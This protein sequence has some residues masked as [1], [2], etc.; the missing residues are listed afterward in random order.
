MGFSNGTQ[1]LEP[2][3]KP[4]LVPLALANQIWFCQPELWVL[5]EEAGVLM[6]ATVG[7]Q[8]M[9]AAKGIGAKYLVLLSK[10]W[11]LKSKV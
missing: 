3:T 2:C 11:A 8:P 1:F 7:G 9:P 5:F 4:F 6:A 10:V